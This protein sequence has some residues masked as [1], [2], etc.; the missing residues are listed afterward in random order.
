[1]HESRTPGELSAQLSVEPPKKNWGEWIAFILSLMVGAGFVW[2]FY[3]SPSMG[4]ELIWIWVLTT[5]ILGAIGALIARAH[6]LSIVA[7]F[8]ASPITPFHPALSSGMVSAA[9]E[10]WIRK[11]SALKDDLNN[12]RGWWRNRVARTLLVFFLTNLGT[13]I[14]FWIAGPRV[15]G[16]VISG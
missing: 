2:A 16:K 11:P 8:I 14:G 1:M 13:A 7:A 9:V 15:F 10:L 12:W 6:P 4:W 3:K 5:G